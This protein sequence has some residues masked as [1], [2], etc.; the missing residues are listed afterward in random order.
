MKRII[1]NT[2]YYI[3]WVALYI[4]LDDPITLVDTGVF[5]EENYNLFLENLKTLGLGIKDIKR[6]VLTHGHCDHFGMARKVAE[7]SGAKIYIHPED[8]EKAKDRFNYYVRLIPIME[9][10]GVPGDFYPLF[11]KFLKWEDNFCLGLPEDG[12]EFLSEGKLEFEHFSLDVI[13]TPGHSKGHI[14]LSDGKRV[15]SGDLIFTNMTS[16]PIIDADN[17]GRR[18]KSINMHLASLDRLL[19]VGIEE[20]FP[21][22]KEERGNFR[23]AVYNLYNRFESKCSYILDW[24]MT[25]K[26]ATPYELVEVTYENLDRTFIYVILSEMMGRLDYLENKGLISY[27]EV[28]GKIYCIPLTNSY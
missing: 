21:S 22:H 26:K 7:E 9:S 1:L 27:E 28:D 12:V 5:S 4:I 23:E 10:L 16:E 8:Y 2:P 17:S 13:H 20:F 15:I 11:V 24:L 18:L 25:L 19:G 14:V 6:I 3:G